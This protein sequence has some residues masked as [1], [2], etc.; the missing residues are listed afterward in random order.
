[1]E[2]KLKIDTEEHSDNTELL[3]IGNRIKFFSFAFDLAFNLSR[4]FED[5]KDAYTFEE[6]AMMISRTL[7]Q[8]GLSHSLLEEL[9]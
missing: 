6:V 4:C 2:I 5:E 7:E 3:L 1:M 8:N 9:G